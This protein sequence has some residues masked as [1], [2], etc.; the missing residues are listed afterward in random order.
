MNVLEPSIVIERWHGP[1]FY[2]IDVSPLVAHEGEGTVD[3][4]IDWPINCHFDSNGERGGDCG[5]G[6]YYL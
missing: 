6:R 4:V 2:I 1:V 5:V 3:C